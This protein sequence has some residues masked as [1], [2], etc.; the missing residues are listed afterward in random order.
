VP[1]LAF[2]TGEIGNI[3]YNYVPQFFLDN[4]E[5]ED[6]SSRYE[7]LNKNYKRIPVELIEYVLYKEFNKSKYLQKLIHIYQNR[8]V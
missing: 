6:W 3:L 7:D 4:F 8:R 1:I 5:I 2:K